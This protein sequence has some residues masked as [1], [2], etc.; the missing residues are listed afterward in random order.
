MIGSPQSFMFTLLSRMVDSVRSFLLSRG[1]AI[2]AGILLVVLMVWFL[3]PLVG[4]KSVSAR[5]WFLAILALVLM[6]TLLIKHW[7]DDRLMRVVNGVR[8]FSVFC[9]LGY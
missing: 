3:G 7:G 2:F 1:G 5:L 9:C 8:N 4:L 6:V